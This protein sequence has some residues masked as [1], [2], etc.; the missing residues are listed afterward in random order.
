M[1][2]VSNIDAYYEGIQALRQVSLELAEGEIVCL[3]GANGAGKTTLLNVISCLHRPKKGTIEFSGKD[4]THFIPENMVNEGVIH[5]P[6]GRELFKPM[7]VKENLEMGAFLRFKKKSI[8][9]NIEQD[10]ELVLN[11]FPILKT[12]LDQTA[13]TLSGGEQQMLA[14]GRGLMGGP[15]LLL[16]DEPSL[17]LAPMVTR[18]IFH[19]IAKLQKEGISILLVEQNAKAALEISK[20]TYVM[21]TGRIVLSGPSEKM[22][23]N[24]EVKKTFLGRDYVGN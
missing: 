20:R 23:Q 14:I 22:L 16:M 15:K 17:G 13:G 3:I 19:V 2:K 9:N 4:I 6:E 10:M 18:E 5:I 24:E 12:R 1:L 7:T 11:L 21:E 8:R